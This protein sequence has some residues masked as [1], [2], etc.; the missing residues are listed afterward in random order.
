MP[1]LLDIYTEDGLPGQVQHTHSLAEGLDK[2]KDALGIAF[3]CAFTCA[4]LYQIRCVH[5]SFVSFKKVSLEVRRDGGSFK[6][7]LAR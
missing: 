5:K 1:T 2:F 3:V 7:Q 4:A 6:K